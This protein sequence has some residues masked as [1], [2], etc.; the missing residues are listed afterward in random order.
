[1]TDAFIE[2]APHF[3]VDEG[4]TIEE[5]VR[6]VEHGIQENPAAYMRAL[7]QLGE[8]ATA[9]TMA[10]G[11]TDTEAATVGQGAV[12]QLANFFSRRLDLNVE[13]D[14]DTERALAAD[15]AHQQLMLEHR[16]SQ[17]DIRLAIGKMQHTTREN[18]NAPSA[19]DAVRRSRVG[20]FIARTM[21]FQRQH[22]QPELPA[23][24]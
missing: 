3:V 4:S 2:V 24:G 8:S 6:R 15:P 16:N 10:I 14:A 12:S 9:G 7:K 19:R 1:M 23:V 20:L 13:F 21:D 5:Q 11:A 17:E 18:P 22:G